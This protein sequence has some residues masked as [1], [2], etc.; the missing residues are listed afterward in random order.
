MM[1]DGYDEPGRFQIQR[2]IHATLN[3]PGK[4]VPVSDHEPP[5]E[6]NGNAFDAFSKVERKGH[7][8]HA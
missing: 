1:F 6:Y 5:A 3:V 8:A 7:S 4:W 2:V